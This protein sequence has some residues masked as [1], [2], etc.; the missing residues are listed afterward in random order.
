MS[1]GLEEPGPINGRVS[2]E[3]L[4]L[5][6]CVTWE[7]LAAQNWHCSSCLLGRFALLGYFK[8]VQ[9]KPSGSLNFVE[10]RIDKKEGE[11]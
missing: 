7:G 4:S 8:M 10:T 5:P 1:K 3:L 9:H 2:R 11:E 6:W